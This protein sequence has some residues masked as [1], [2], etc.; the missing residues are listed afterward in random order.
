MSTDWGPY[1]DECEEGEIWGRS[2]TV[3]AILSGIPEIIALYR[4]EAWPDE[5]SWYGCY[6]HYPPNFLLRHKGH[7]L[8]LMDEYGRIYNRADSID[9]QI[10]RRKR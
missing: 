5:A 3:D 2:W 1:C 7:H 8:G 10:S 4:T 9:S 6:D